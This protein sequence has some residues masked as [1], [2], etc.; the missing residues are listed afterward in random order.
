MITDGFLTGLAKLAVGESYDVPAYLTVS[1]DSDVIA[2]ATTT[3]LLGEFGSR[4][5]LALDRTDKTAKYSAVRT[6]AIVG[7][8]GDLLHAV[9]L[10]PSDSG[11]GCQSVIV[12]PGLTQTSNFDIDFNFEI[13]MRRV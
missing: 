10:F 13:S 6:G 9:A 3:S 2:S 11:D 7:S 5:S 8:S 12:L 4:I 1:S